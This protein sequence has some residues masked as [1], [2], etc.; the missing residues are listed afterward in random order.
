MAERRKLLVTGASSG[1]GAAISIMAATRGYDVAVHY[2]GNQAGAEASADAV[3]AAGGMAYLV[4]ADLGNLEQVASLFAKL[5]ADFGR[6]D[7]L[8]NNAGITVPKARVEDYDAA[9]LSRLFAVNLSAPIL[10]AGE[11]VKRMSRRHGGQGGVIV[12]ISSV[13]ARLGSAN[14][15]VDYAASKAGI[16]IFTKGLSDEVAAEGIRVCA[17]RPGLI[18]TPIHQKGGVPD[19]AKELAPTVPMQRT[20][21]PEEVAEAVLWLLSDAA[22]YVTGTVLEVTGGR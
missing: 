10:V 6:I 13:A 20:G 9:R 4:K 19:R 22:S 2:S 3:R 5:D 21:A 8:V 14:F 11:A 17:I 16:E 15:F 12:S 1:I 7:A 18:D